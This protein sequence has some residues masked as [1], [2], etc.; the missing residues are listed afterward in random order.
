MTDQIGGGY[1]AFGTILA[2][3]D[4]EAV[5]EFT[6]VAWVK[7]ISGPSISRETIETTN[8]QS[9]NRMAQFVASLSD[10]GEV[11]FDVN[12]NPGDATHDATTG[13]F[14]MLS[15]TQPRHWRLIF[16]IESVTPG[17]YYGYAFPALVSGFQPGAPVK[18]VLNASITLKVAG[19][20]TQGAYTVD[21][22]YG[23]S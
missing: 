9:P 14:A 7:D 16:P 11:T 10:G 3:G 13:L 17:Q 18:D 8:H 1:A 6:A 19:A 23:L 2:Y 21:D 20:V 22:I 4:G 5:E 15:E 12:L